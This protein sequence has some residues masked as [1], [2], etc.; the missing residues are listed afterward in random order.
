M[1][2]LVP[3]VLRLNVDVSFEA[4]ARAVKGKL[5]KYKHVPFLPQFYSSSPSIS[6]LVYPSDQATH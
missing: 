6:L 3:I 2:M 4:P 5:H 1:V